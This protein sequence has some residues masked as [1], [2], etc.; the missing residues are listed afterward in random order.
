MR[1]YVL[2]ASKKL[3]VQNNSILS[4]ALKNLP[5]IIFIAAYAFFIATIYTRIFN[6]SEYGQYSFYIALAGPVIYVFTEWLAQPIS[7]YYSEYKNS[8]SLDVLWQT[9]TIFMLGLISFFTIM[10]FAFWILLRVRI[11]MIPLNYAVPTLLIIA[12]QSVTSILLPIFTSSFRSRVWRNITAFTP[13]LATAVTS[14]FL[15]IFGRHAYYILYGQAISLAVFLPLVI[16]LSGWQPKLNHL[17][18]TP[19]IKSTMQRMSNYGIPMMLWFFSSNILDV[20]DRLLLHWFRSEK[21]LGVYAVSY[22]MMSG[23]VALLNL[24]INLATGP[25]LYN[26]WSQGRREEASEAIID[27]SQMYIYFAAVLAVTIALLGPT[28]LAFI[29][30]EDF[31]DGIGVIIPIMLARMVWGLSMIGQKTLELNEKTKTLMR[32]ALWSALANTILNII[33]IPLYGIYAA[34]FS[35]L[36]CCL[37]YMFLVHKLSKKIMVWQINFSAI[38]T[39]LIT[40]CT[41]LF[42]YAVF[43]VTRFDNIYANIIIEIVAILIITRSFLKYTRKKSL[44]NSRTPT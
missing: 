29:I 10:A 27:M 17:N 43:Q 9:L 28:L 37:L 25:I 15:L 4:D 41:I 19:Q 26:F 22:S 2:N 42:A 14:I 38:K 7:R 33:F 44:L 1:I 8:G 40:A 36:F 21:E 13:I 35:T 3:F 39:P 20:Q 6:A 18:L 5:S 31:R 34:A 12:L 23:I 30:G 32:L 24:P 11:F 16:Y